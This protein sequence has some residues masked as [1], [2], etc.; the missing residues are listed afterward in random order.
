LRC[1]CAFNVSRITFSKKQ[2]GK[3]ECNRQLDM[4]NQTI[5]PQT[6]YQEDPRGRKKDEPGE[7]TIV[8][9][10]MIVHGTRTARRKKHVQIADM[11]T[12]LD[13]SNSSPLPK[14]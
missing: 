8:T 11:R 5:L 13:D 3:Q 12:V 2:Y 14:T 10:Q 4:I 6:R 7:T 9:L 1:N